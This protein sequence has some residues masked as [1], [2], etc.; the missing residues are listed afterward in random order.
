MRIR[1]NVGRFGMVVAVVLATIGCSTNPLSPDREALA[2]TRA[3]WEASGIDSYVFEFQRLCFC[4]PV[5]IRQVR[6]EVVDGAVS[7]AVYVDTG[8]PVDDPSVSVPT[9]ED[10][11]DEIQDAIDREAD[12]LETEY[13]SQAGYPIS[14]SIDYIEQAIDD[15]MAFTV[16][17]LDVLVPAV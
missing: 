9:I 16:P 5:V 8:D 10:L 14:V 15:E 4:P 7:S 3:R 1:L 11:F 6:I 17:T 13:D 12:S 2:S